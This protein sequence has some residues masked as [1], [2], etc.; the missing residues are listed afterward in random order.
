M[1]NTNGNGKD[2]DPIVK[3]VQLNVMTKH[4]QISW[5]RFNGKNSSA[6]LCREQGVDSDVGPHIQNRAARLDGIAKKLSRIFLV[7]I[8]TV[9]YVHPAG[10]AHVQ[11]V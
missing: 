3:T 7:E 9:P 10:L 8:G 4:L 2:G 5:I 11:V 6:P 1:L